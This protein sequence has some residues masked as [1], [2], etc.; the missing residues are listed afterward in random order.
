MAALEAERSK[1][2]ASS[3]GVADLQAKLAACE[4]AAVAPEGEQSVVRAP[5]K[6]DKRKLATRDK[7]ARRVSAKKARVARVV[8][9][10]PAAAVAADGTPALDKKTNRVLRDTD[11]NDPLAGI[12]TQ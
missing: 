6:A 3:G 11:D 1:Q 2:A 8:R 10:E 4:Q 7:R 12:D 5:T 9:S